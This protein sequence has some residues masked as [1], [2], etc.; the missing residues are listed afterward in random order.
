MNWDQTISNGQ[1]FWMLFVITFL[2]ILI[3]ARIY[4]REDTTKKKNANR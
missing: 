1:I 2:L 4:R 3:V